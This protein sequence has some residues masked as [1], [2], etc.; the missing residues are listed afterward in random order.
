MRLANITFDAADPPKLAAFW[1]AAADRTLVE[2][3]TPDFVVLTS[4]EDTLRWLF[5]QV[6]EGKSAKNRQHLD[7]HAEDRVAEVARLKALGATEGE[8]HREPHV[9]WTVMKDPEGNEFCVA[10]RTGT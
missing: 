1:A 4:T 8:T 3:S 9:A 5:T 6:P 2:P 10:Q 7:F